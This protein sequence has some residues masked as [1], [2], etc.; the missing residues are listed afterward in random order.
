MAYSRIRLSITAVLIA[1]A[2]SAPAAA[3]LPTGAKAPEFKLQATLGGNAFTFNLDEALQKGPVV[4][5]FYPAA[6]TTGCTIEAHEFADAIDQ[7]KALGATVIGVS[8]DPLDKLQKF[9]T[10][11]CRSK[12]AV[13]ADTDQT[14]MK[15]YDAVL[16]QHPQYANR[17]SYVIAPDGTI[18]Y[19]YTSLDPALHVQNTLT[20]LKAWKADHASGST[21]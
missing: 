10:S 19:T 5:Y 13:A 3:A 6:F 2:L 21:P 14:V 4:L 20:A 7:Y 15:A 17:T 1:A 11:E 8:H 16:P 18:V 9:S 12:F